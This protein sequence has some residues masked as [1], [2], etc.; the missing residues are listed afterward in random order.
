M[1][2]PPQQSQYP[3]TLQ[4]WERVLTRA[5]LRADGDVSEGRRSRS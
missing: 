3:A 5:L 4:E 2:A 1:T